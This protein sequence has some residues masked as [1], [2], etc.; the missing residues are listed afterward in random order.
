M[1]AEKFSEETLF[2][3]LDDPRCIAAGE[4]GLD[5][6]VSADMEKQQE[7][8]LRQAI[9]A[10]EAGKGLVIHCVRR[11]PE[12]LS[13]RKK[14]DPKQKKVWLIHGFRAKEA[15]GKELLKAECILSLSPTYLRRLEQF[16]SW[17]PVD[18]FLLETDT[19]SS[20]ELPFLYEKAG[21]LLQMDQK[22]L[23]ERL[24]KTFCS[25]ASL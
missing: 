13:L 14:I 2:H 23:R 5:P 10:Q 21:G 6:F 25:F 4:C 15:I 24:Y 12:L 7:V 3:L 20:H 11:F 9:L 19:E 1:D 8:F 22:T 16:P 17:L 18:R